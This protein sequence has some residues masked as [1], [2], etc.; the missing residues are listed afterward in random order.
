M[1]F[2]TTPSIILEHL[3]NL[4]PILSTNKINP[5]LEGFLFE[6]QKDTLKITAYS[7]DLRIRTS[8]PVNLAGTD[9]SQNFEE[10]FVIP[11]KKIMDILQTL[12][13]APITFT[14]M[15][16]ESAIKLKTEN[17][18]Y[19]IN[20][21]NGDQ[22]P[23]FSENIEFEHSITIQSDILKAGLSRTL[24]AASDDIELRPNL[25]GIYCQFLENETIFTSTDTHRLI[26]YTRSDSRPESNL[27]F[28][29]P[30]KNVPII[31]KIL[32]KFEDAVEI[33][34]AKGFI[35]THIG[36][37]E[38]FSKLASG[39]FP[40]YR[41]VFPKN[42]SKILTIDRNQ[43]ISTLRRVKVF[44]ALENNRVQFVIN[45]SLLKVL[46]TN[47][48]YNESAF[49]NLTCTYKGEEFTISFNA[50]L[51]LEQLHNIPSDEI[52][53]EMTEA[54]VAV[55]IRPAQNNPGEKIVSLLMP[56]I[57]Y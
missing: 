32:D 25:C 42:P 46:A 18:E 34:Y 23:P 41:N 20:V 38:I 51:L 26:E 57:N 44:S 8:V 22:Y 50:A 47:E 49:E 48:E 29:I 15:P 6:I 9:T 35:Q 7:Q 36:E 43:L 11:S 33:N 37:Y 5:L 27:T 52:V 17:G 13:E 28:I 39:E 14:L 4:S 3:K 45:G 21:L 30:K 24:F 10:G 2:I 19:K 16:D 55:I 56:L 12:P 40:K 1:M 54:N 31:S 53:F